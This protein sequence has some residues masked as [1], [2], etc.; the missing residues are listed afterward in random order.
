MSR[1][2]PGTISQKG[3]RGILAAVI[4]MCVKD[5]RMGINN[6]SALSS[7]GVAV[8]AISQASAPMLLK[9]SARVVER[10]LKR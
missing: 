6:G 8:D 9:Y 7:T 3:E 5:A 4:G 2:I 10:S 1:G